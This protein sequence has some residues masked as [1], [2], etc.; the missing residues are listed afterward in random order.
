MA[1]FVYEFTAKWQT[2]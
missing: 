1:V 2:Q